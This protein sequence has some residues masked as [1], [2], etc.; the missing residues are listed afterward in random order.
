M[1]YNITKYTNKINMKIFTRLDDAIS[2]DVGLYRSIKILLMRAIQITLQ[3]L[4]SAGSHGISDPTPRNG[5]PI[6]QKSE[7]ITPQ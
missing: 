6:P 2:Y 7:P 3:W 5:D 1:I 4:I